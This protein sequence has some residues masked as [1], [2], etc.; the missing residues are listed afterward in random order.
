MDTQ[1]VRHT[2]DSYP[3]NRIGTNALIV[4]NCSLKN[5]QARVESNKPAARTIVLAANSPHPTALLAEVVGGQVLIVPPSKRDRSHVERNNGVEG[6]L[7]VGTMSNSPTSYYIQ[8]AL[9]S[10]SN[11]LPTLELKNGPFRL[12]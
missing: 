5:R 12:P 1:H 9:L 7:L 4:V 6:S 8:E 3:F 2:D 10:S 11:T